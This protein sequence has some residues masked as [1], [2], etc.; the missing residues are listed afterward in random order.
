MADKLDTKK[1]IAPALSSEVTEVAVH[2]RTI[3]IQLYGM[4]KAIETGDEAELAKARKKYFETD[5]ELS[6]AIH[7]L[8]G[9]SGPK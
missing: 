6:K 1:W 9:L 5:S 4:I 8:G 2:T 7:R 3:L